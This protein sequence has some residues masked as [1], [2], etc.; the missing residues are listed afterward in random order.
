MTTDELINILELS[1]E[2]V[3]LY[4][5]QSPL[6]GELQPCGVFLAKIHG[7]INKSYLFDVERQETESITVSDITS[8][9]LSIDESV[10]QD[11]QSKIEKV[12][13][14]RRI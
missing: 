9:D 13:I 5:Q 8:F 2:I 1:G 3:E 11:M 6:S 7:D 10:S 4:S 14:I 12:G